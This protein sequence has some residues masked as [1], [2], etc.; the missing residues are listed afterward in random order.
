MDLNDIIAASGD[1]EKGREHPILDP[2]TGKPI[3]ITMRIAGPD[4]QIQRRARLAMA[5]EMS[6]MA[7]IDGK[8]SAADREHAH[9]NVLAACVLDW[10]VQEDGQA[11]PCNHANI[12]RVLK[13]GSWL[14][15]QVDAY[16]ADRTAYRQG[17]A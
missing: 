11:I 6:E 4:S 12:L 15:A 9:L 13:A 14:Q 2:V 10:N 3:G 5:D 7:D 17:D 16:A 1:H 8:V